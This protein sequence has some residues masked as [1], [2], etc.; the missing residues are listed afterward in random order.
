M[1]GVVSTD[2]D[3]YGKDYDKGDEDTA[4][5]LPNNDMRQVGSTHWVDVYSIKSHKST[6]MAVLQRQEQGRLYE[7]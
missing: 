5:I 3:D 6:S 1:L 7:R 2:N 4:F